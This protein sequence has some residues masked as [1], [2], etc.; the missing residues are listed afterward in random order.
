MIHVMVP[1]PVHAQA[2]KTDSVRDKLRP[3]LPQRWRNLH[4][5]RIGRERGGTWIS[6][7][8]RV[9]TMAKMPSLSASMRFLP[10]SNALLSV[11]IVLSPA[12]LV[13]VP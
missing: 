5:W 7:I 1:D 6:R 4:V 12:S 11:C 13:V 8:S 9:M 3:Q 2:E 10:N